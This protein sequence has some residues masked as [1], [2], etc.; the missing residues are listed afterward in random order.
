MIAINVQVH[1][2]RPQQVQRWRGRDERVEER[3]IEI[4]ICYNRV[5]DD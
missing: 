2:R 5:P 1:R 3:F 4:P